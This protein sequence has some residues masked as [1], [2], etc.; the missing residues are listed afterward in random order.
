MSRQGKSEKRKVN[1]CYSKINICTSCKTTMQFQL[2][3]E[4]FWTVSRRESTH[5]N[6]L[7]PKNQRYLMCGSHKNLL[8]ISEKN[9]WASVAAGLR[10][11]KKQ[12]WGS[13]FISFTLREMPIIV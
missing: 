1:R 3:D 6:E 8:V 5:N 7:C 2:N 12:V 10:V 4:R 11:I 9:S 13:P